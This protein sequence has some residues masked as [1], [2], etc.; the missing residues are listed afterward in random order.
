MVNMQST[1]VNKQAPSNNSKH[2]MT[3]DK[4]QNDNHMHIQQNLPPLKINQL[5]IS[6]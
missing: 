6:V 2:A 4:K 3:E 1:A 5:T